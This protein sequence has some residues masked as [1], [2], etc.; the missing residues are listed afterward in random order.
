MIARSL[1]QHNMSIAIYAMFYI[2]FLSVKVLHFITGSCVMNVD[3]KKFYFSLCFS[4]CTIYLL[5]S[6]SAGSFVFTWT[7]EPFPVTVFES[8]KNLLASPTQN[9]AY[10]FC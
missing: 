6:F 10:L 5:S 9:F 7:C 1:L 4:Q 8:S 2:L 3:T